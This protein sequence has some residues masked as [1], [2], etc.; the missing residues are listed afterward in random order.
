MATTTPEVAGPVSQRPAVE[1]LPP[2]TIAGFTTNRDSAIVAGTGVGGVGAGAGCDDG[3]TVT[4][5]ELS[6]HALAPTTTAMTARADVARSDR[7]ERLR[8]LRV[9]GK[10][11]GTCGI[12]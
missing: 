11:T 1:L 8:R 10:S 3:A 12:V 9:G 5:G 2:V 4:A 7:I 6:L